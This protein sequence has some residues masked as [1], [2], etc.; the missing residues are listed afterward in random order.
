[1]S[2]NDI[3]TDFERAFKESFIDMKERVIVCK[4]AVHSAKTELVERMDGMLDDEPVY[5]ISVAAAPEKN[6][7]NLEILKYFGQRMGMR[8]EI[9]SGLTTSI[10]RIKIRNSSDF[11]NLKE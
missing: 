6:R 3:L 10:K 9:L 8:A 1:M 11:I 4:I 2:K 5:K 7:A